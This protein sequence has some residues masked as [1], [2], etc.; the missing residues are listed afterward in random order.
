MS[1]PLKDAAA[2]VGI[3]ATPFTK[4]S[5]VSELQLASECVAAAIADAGLAPTDVDGLVTFSLDTNDEI[6]VARA[7]G[8]GDLTFF[9]RIPY[10]G[11]AAIGIV[12]QAAMAVATGSARAV[13][14]YRA[15]NGRSGQR[16][17]QGVGGDIVT[18]DLIHWS[19]YMPSGLMTPTSWVAMFTQRYMHEYGAK[20]TD[21]AQVAVSTRKHAVNNPAA[22]FHGRPLT[23]EEHQA[24]RFIVEPLR[25]YDCCQETDGGCA[26]V[27]TTP[28][29]A[30]DLE[31]PG[32]LIRGVAQAS[33]AD[34]EQMTS[35][36]RPSIATLPEMDLVARQVYAM[37]G[38]SPDDI[39]A[40]VI[41]DAF[42][43]IVL[44]QLEA[45]GFCSVGEG[46]DFVQDGNLEVGG[47]LPTNT[48]GGQLSE[49][50]IHGV[51]GIAEGVRLI[52]G[53]STNQP[54]KNDHVLV[55]G[56]VGVPTSGMILGKL[57]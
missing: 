22:F 28:E 51:N 7:V 32:A 21:L 17:S 16:Y 26:V 15:L 10:G 55:T 47:R 11:G 39:D 5:G 18:S 42:T 2:I 34:Q 27:I 35:F 3:G 29:R 56:G 12:H 1:S 45:F 43:S 44:W 30:R 13:V 57:D 49:A 36:Y 53:T 24:S 52:R 50:Y 46:K 54:A 37:S 48:H 9:S 38:L 4:N 23:I 6:E 14:A 31:Q 19:W 20:S 8:I 41:Y 40:A 25:L 33:A